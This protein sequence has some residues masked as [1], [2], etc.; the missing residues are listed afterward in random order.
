VLTEISVGGRSLGSASKFVRPR[1]VES[2]FRVTVNDP[3]SNVAVCPHR[4]DTGEQEGGEDG[5]CFGLRY[6]E[7]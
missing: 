6:D 4:G 7:L 2:R 3:V 5:E 1:W